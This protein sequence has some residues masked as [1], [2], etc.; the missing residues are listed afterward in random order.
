MRI[1]SAQKSV[2]KETIDLSIIIPTL[3][4][5]DFIG[6][7]LD[8]ISNQTVSPK[9]IIVV[10]AFSKDKTTKEVKKRQAKMANLKYYQIPQKTIA[11]QRNF[12]ESKTAT[13][14]LLFLDA[15]MMLK[16]K[17]DLEKYFKEVLQKKADVAAART[18]PDVN[19]W[20][21]TV[22]FMVEDAAFK[23]SQ[24]IWPVITARNLY[25][26]KEVFE[27]A[28]GFNEELV[29]GEDQ[30]LVQR[31]IKMGGKLIFLKTVQLI[32][33]VRRVEI[34]GRRR[35]ALRMI[36]FGINIFFRGYK[37]SKIEYEFGKF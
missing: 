25:M 36:L 4:E 17:Y 15:D 32:T 3:N 6:R 35:Y 21:N 18:L 33:S 8:S 22:Y 20:K 24:Y 7:L 11:R 31:I 1:N 30:E 28:G 14:Y 10:D 13:E 2:K 34:E 9:E 23:A 26:P 27:K 12:G 19:S 16:R 37:K 5:E 29:V